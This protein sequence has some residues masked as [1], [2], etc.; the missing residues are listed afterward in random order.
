MTVFEYTSGAPSRAAHA[1]SVSGNVLT[2]KLE[3]FG[4]LQDKDRDLL[5]ELVQKSRAVSANTDL[6]RDGDTPSHVNL[7]LAGFACRYKI[8]PDGARQ[9]FGYLIPGDICDLNIFVLKKMDHS[10]ATLADSEIVDISP[11]QIL[12]LLDNPRIARALWWATLVDEGTL[13][14]WVVNMGQ[15]EAAERIAHLFCELHLRLKGVGLVTDGAFRLPV[16]QME[17]AD[18][19]G[20]S[21]VHVNRSIQTLRGQNL[22]RLEGR[23]LENSRRSPARAVQ[24]IQPELFAP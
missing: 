9:I 22:I 18:T 12:D 21:P 23:A 11:Q 24:R 20:L 3:L 13:R 10:I 8:M 14:E 6:I 19:L 16:T 15:R 1:T 5:D 17:L 7:V 4:P 2:R